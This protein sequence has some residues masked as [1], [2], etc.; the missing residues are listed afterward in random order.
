VIV[1]HELERMWQERSVACFNVL[2]LHLSGGTEE[3]HEYAHSQQPIFELGPPNT[4]ECYY[5]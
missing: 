2:S 5:P 3:N 4:K 1:N